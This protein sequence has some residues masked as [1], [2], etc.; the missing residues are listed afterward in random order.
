MKKEIKN[1]FKVF[2]MSFILISTILLLISTVSAVAIGLPY[3][4]GNPFII[5]P[6]QTGTVNLTI[7]NMVGEED[8]TMKA[9]IIQGNEIASLKKDEYF[10]PITKEVQVPIKITIPSNA[11]LNTTYKVKVSFKTITPSSEGGVTMGIGIVS[12]FDVLVKEGVKEQPKEKLETKT[13]IIISIIILIIII[14]AIVLKKQKLKK[15]S[16]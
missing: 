3:W 10:V 14:I 4:E 16:K 15:I 8:I 12:T 7:Q 5:S 13:L 6:G 9:E 2:L 11:T 1:K